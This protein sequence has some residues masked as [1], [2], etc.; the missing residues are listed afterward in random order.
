[1]EKPLRFIRKKEVI[2]RLGISTNSLDLKI[3]DGLFTKPIQVSDRIIAW[4]EYELDSI[5]IHLLQGCQDDEIKAVVSSLTENR[6][7]VPL[8]PL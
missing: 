5:M 6:Q 2:N 4:P 7:P 3:K 8:A 1:M